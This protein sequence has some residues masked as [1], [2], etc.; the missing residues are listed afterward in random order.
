[1]AGPRWISDGMT[2]SEKEEIE[3]G[4][5]KGTNLSQTAAQGGRTSSLSASLTFFLADS[6]NSWR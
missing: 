4:K 1:M 5:V 6:R 3:E 2:G